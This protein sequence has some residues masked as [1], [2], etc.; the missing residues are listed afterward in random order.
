MSPSACSRWNQPSA[1]TSKTRS[2]SRLRLVGQ[3]VADLE[4]RAVH[5]DVDAA[6]AS[7]GPLPLP[8][9]PAPGRSGRPGASAR[10]RLR[11]WIGV[12]RR[13]VRRGRARCVPSSR[14]T[15]FGVGRSPRRLEA[16]GEVALEPVAVAGEA[17]QVRVGGVGLRRRGRAGGTSPPDAAG[18]VGGDRR[19]D[20]AGGAGDE[21]RRC[22]VRC[23]RRV[24]L[25]GGRLDEPDRPAQRRRRSRSRR[26]RGRAASRRAACRPAPRSCGSAAK[27]TALTSASARSRA[28]A[29]A[30]PRHGAAQHGGR[31]GRVVAVA[32]AEAGRRDQERPADCRQRAHRDGEEL[33]ADAQ[34]LVPGG[35]LERSERPFVVERGQPVD[36]LHRPRGGP[37]GDLRFQRRGV[38]GAVERQHLDAALGE[39][40]RERRADAAA[41][42]A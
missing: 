25:G 41:R 42:R 16:V 1:L 23:A 12:E 18:E 4:P 31:A 33:D 2:Y 15:S 3:E 6:A 20:A 5:E 40:L 10:C 29:L 37:F 28:S 17:R 32:A 21:E 14:S 35:G 30:K 9:R 36:A 11:A 8:R 19:H 39:P 7:R 24:A 38:R 13:P 26:R 34:R 27:S 22:P